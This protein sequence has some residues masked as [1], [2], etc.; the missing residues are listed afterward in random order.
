MVVE[1]QTDG[2]RAGELV[3]EAKVR[4]GQVAGVGF[5]V[6]EWEGG[7]TTPCPRPIS[8][9]VSLEERLVDGTLVWFAELV[10]GMSHAQGGRKDVHCLVLVESSD[11]ATYRRVG[12][13]V[14]KDSDWVHAQYPEAK[15][16]RLR[17]I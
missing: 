7:D 2:P 15:M 6:C 1:V 11:H 5:V 4:A 8:A 3:L 9:T 14:W 16:K 12:Y 13:A 10:A 17:I